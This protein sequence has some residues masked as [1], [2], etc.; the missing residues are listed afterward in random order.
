MKKKLLTRKKIL[1]SVLLFI[2]T[3]ILVGV[4]LTTYLSSK[5]ERV[6]VNK[7]YVIDTGKEPALEDKNVINILLLGTDQYEEKLTAADAIMILTIDKINNKIKLCSLMRDLYLDPPEGYSK[8]NLNYTI[9]SGG[10]DQILKTIN[11]NF[12]LQ[13]D[14]FVQVN[15]SSLPIIIDKLSGVEMEITEDELQYINGYIDSIDKGNN[16]KTEHITYAGKQLLNGT[17]A[18]AYC[19]IRYTAGRDYR[20]T[21]RHRDV[22]AALFDKMRDTN[23]TEIPGIVSG[24]LPLVSTNL[25]NTEILSLSSTVLSLGVNKIEQSR[26]PMDGDYEMILTDMYHLMIDIDETAEKIHKFIYSLED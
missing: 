2:S 12:N 16:T 1:I 20:R 24:L 18:S 22:L 6:E 15:L 4:I 19:R 5:V 26:F 17:Q 8:T 25:T 9:I 10:Y 3:I 7:N 21:E 13:I 23:V 14:K 11:T